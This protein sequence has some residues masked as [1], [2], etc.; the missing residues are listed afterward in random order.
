MTEL[1]L[2]IHCGLGM[3]ADDLISRLKGE[4]LD[5]RFRSSWVRWSGDGCRGGP[6]VRSVF[7]VGTQHLRTC[8]ARNILYLDKRAEDTEGPSGG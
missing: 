2:M 4:E 7:Y 5:A 8:R 6:A 3:L 1:S